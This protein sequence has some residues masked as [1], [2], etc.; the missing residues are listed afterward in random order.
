MKLTIYRKDNRIKPKNI[1]A[2]ETQ[3]S[4]IKLMKKMCEGP[5]K[6]DELNDGRAKTASS[7]DFSSPNKALGGTLNKK[8][9][10]PAYWD[11]MREKK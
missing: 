2:K 10:Y 6:I 11:K 5:H 9:A 1:E 8:T 7:G 3:E 4:P